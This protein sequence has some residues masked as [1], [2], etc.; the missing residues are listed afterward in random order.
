MTLQ[1]A[2]GLADRPDA[3]VGQL[4]GFTVGALLQRLGA[5]LIG[6]QLEDRDTTDVGLAA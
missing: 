1:G 2:D 6:L 5:T 3:A 4:A